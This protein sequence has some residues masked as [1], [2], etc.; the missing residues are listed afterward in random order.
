M[1]LKKC[2]VPTQFFVEISEHLEK[3]Q[4]LDRCSDCKELRK[5]IQTLHLQAEVVRTKQNETLKKIRDVGKK[6]TKI[7]NELRDII[8]GLQ[9]EKSYLEKVNKNLKESLLKENSQKN[10]V[11]FLSN[12]F[13]FYIKSNFGTKF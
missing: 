12:D 5:Q 10:N 13:F 1:K 3:E 4:V 9:G 8:A 6:N 2:V 11:I 7:I